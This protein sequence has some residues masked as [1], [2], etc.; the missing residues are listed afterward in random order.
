MKTVTSQRLLVIFAAAT[1]CLVSVLAFF[2]FAWDFQDPRDR[3]R[4]EA[5]KIVFQFLLVTLGG[6]LIFFYLNYRRD[7]DQAELKERQEQLAKLAA[8]RAELQELLMQLGDAHRRLKVVKRQMRAQIYR[9]DSAGEPRPPFRMRGDAFERA[10]DALLCAQIAAEEVRDIVAIRTHLLPPC[11]II[12][13]RRVL[14]YGARYFHDV[15]QDY[16][17]CLVQRDGEEYVITA[18]CRNLVNFLFA[19]TPPSNLPE[20][21]GEQLKEE[22]EKMKDDARSLPARHVALERIE[23]LRKEDP[24]KRRYRIV[25]T[26]CFALAGDE[27]RAAMCPGLRDDPEFLRITQES[28]D[29]YASDGADATVAPSAKLAAVDG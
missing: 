11:E 8:R 16:E 24:F 27:I 28:D 23:E 14:R 13:V 19:R 15:Y 9:M 2:A 5:L 26:E 7:R 3:Y 21:N 1:L 12:K 29:D 10:M 22:F 20:G 17:R 18:D 25:A 6:G 4:I